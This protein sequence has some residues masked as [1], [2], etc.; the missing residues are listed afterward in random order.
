MSLFSSSLNDFLFRQL[1]RMLPSPY[2]TVEWHYNPLCRSCP[3]DSGCR[4]RAL[5]D[6]ELGSMPN[7]SLDEAR[8]LKRLLVISHGDQYSMKTTENRITDIEEL[9]TLLA[10]QSKLD[11]LERSFPST[12]K[13][14]KR[15]LGLSARNRDS[16]NSS[17]I[18]EAAKT[19]SIRVRQSMFSSPLSLTHTSSRRSD[20]N[21]TSLTLAMKTSPS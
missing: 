10:D 17:V 11:N 21:A 3:Y 9:H 4:F 8:V 7:I 15:I 2:E 12:T 20:L 14:A 5:R 18:V 16:S 1:P 13:R 19:N 6:G